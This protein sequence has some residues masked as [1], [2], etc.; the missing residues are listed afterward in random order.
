[1]GLGEMRR[2]RVDTLYSERESRR[3]V[4]K[5]SCFFTFLQRVSPSM[6]RSIGSPGSGGRLRLLPDCPVCHVASRPPPSAMANPPQTVRNTGFPDRPFPLTSPTSPFDWARGFPKPFPAGDFTS[7]LPSPEPL[8]GL[9]TTLSPAT[10]TGNFP[11]GPSAWRH[12]GL[13][14]VTVAVERDAEGQPTLAMDAPRSTA[15]RDGGGLARSPHPGASETSESPLRREGSGF[16]WVCDCPQ[17][18]NAGP[19]CGAGQSGRSIN[20]RLREW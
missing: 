15:R 16:E 18:Q 14:P 7:Q 6:T 8:G 13:Q 5:R 4:V 10:P 1:M 3:F 12:S 19:E 11:R 17:S 20:A 9:V 2:G